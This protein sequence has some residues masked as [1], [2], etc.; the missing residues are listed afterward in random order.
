MGL[1]ALFHRDDGTR[2]VAGKDSPW[3]AWISATRT[4]NYLLGDPL[5]E[6]DE[7][8]DTFPTVVELTPRWRMSA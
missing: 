2:D 8:A 4:R 5:A 3:D 7:C 1:D 6:R